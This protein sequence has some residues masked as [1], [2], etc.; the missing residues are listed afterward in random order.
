MSAQKEFTLSLTTVT[1]E[2]IAKA[3]S[4]SLP[5][6]EF[7]GIVASSL[8][9]AWETVCK[10]ANKLGHQD[11]FALLAPDHMADADRAQ[12]LRAMA[13]DSIRSAL[14]R[15]HNVTLAF[16]NCHA[17]AAVRKGNEL[18]PRFQRFVSMEAQVLA[19]RPELRDC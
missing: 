17:V 15:H 9:F 18:D 14:E 1:E 8:P 6:E 19:Q 2:H 12:L 4:G 3:A 11:G 7:V 16:Q 5:D 13:S 10:L